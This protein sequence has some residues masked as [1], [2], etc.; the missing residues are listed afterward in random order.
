MMLRIPAL[1][2]WVTT[3]SRNG[4]ANG[5]VNFGIGGNTNTALKGFTITGDGHG[6]FTAGE[7]LISNCIIENNTYRGVHSTAGSPKVMNCIIRGNGSRGVHVYADSSFVVKNC[8]IHDNGDAGIYHYPSVALGGSPVIV[9]NTIVSNTNYGIRAY[10]GTI[11]TNNILW[12]NGANLYGCEATYCCIENGGGGTNIDDDPCFVDPNDSYY[13]LASNSPCI[14]I[15][16]PNQDYTGEKD[17][18]GDNRVIDISGK[19]DDVN[20]IDIGAD[21]YDPNS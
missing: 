17:I 5:A 1:W 3:I 16:N 8:L 13:H 18:D 12:G 21:E 9:G 19:G 4:G 7:P 6:V 15:G 14:D 20:D 2:I 11:I 10:A